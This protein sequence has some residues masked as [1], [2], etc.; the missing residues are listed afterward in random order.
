MRPIITL[1]CAAVLLAA[2]PVRAEP[3][4]Q[5]TA[6]QIFKSASCDCCTKWMAHMSQNGFALEAKEMANTDLHRFKVHIGLK[7]DQTSCHTAM[8]GGYA[9]EGHVPAEDV[10]R[11]L[12]E[13]PDAIGLSV[14]GMPVGS[15]GMESGDQKDP[16]DV[17]LIKKDGT[18]EVFAKH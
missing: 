8:I 7:P 5:S 12:A 2:V 17:L 13:K 4:P 16:Y 6:G 18:S 11:L 14:P 9:I 15:P 10:K 3:A 1:L